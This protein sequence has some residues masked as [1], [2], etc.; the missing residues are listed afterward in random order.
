MEALQ[1]IWFI[2]I[3]VLWLGYLFLEGFDL[4]VGVLMKTMAKDEKERRVLLNTIGPV[5][6]GNEVWL[7]TAGGAT[8]AAFPLWYASLFSALYLPL[9][10]ALVALIFRAVSIEYRGKG[11]SEQWRSFWTWAM[12]LGSGVAAFCVGAMLALT[13]TGLPIN[14]NGDNTG[15]PFAWVNI[16]AIIGGLGVLGFSILHGMLFVSLKTDGDIRHRARKVA[17]TWG[18]VL[19]LPLVAWVVIVQILS[20]PVW[21]WLII[22]VAAVCAVIS[23]LRLR[24][25][26]EKGAFIFQALFLVA[27]VVSVFTSV[28]PTVLPSTIDP[29]FSLTLANASSSN[30]T[31]GVMLVV[32]VIFVPLVLLYTIYSYVLF[33]KRLHV[34]RIPEAHQIP[35]AARVTA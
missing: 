15:G 24:G 34:D 21:S 3:A 13:T 9:T 12:A 23:W 27:G 19:L 1:V 11:H 29:S 8:F 33:A 10:L 35:V 18:P 14:E 30:Y 17:A 6:D 7:L 31:L 5:W 16:Y 25:G 26:D 2:L 28:F 22:V 4:G 32:T 20:G